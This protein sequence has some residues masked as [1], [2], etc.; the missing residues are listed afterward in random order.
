MLWPSRNDG[1]C[2]WSKITLSSLEITKKL[3][4]VS[5]NQKLKDVGFIRLRG[6]NGSTAY[7]HGLSLQILK[8]IG[9]ARNKAIR[10]WRDEQSFKVISWNSCEGA[11]YKL[12]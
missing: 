2:H 1:S 6:R 5:G 10:L 3:L 8:N 4:K 12:K 9:S 11:L 7:V